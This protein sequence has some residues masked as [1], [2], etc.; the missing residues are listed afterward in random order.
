MVKVIET[1]GVLI[2]TQI[3]AVLPDW[4]GTKLFGSAYAVSQTVTVWK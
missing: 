3:G 4:V 2:K 1:E